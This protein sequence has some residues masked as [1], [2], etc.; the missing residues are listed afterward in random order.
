MGEG[1]V[2]IRDVSGEKVGKSRGGENGWVKKSNCIR[3]K[4]EGE[5][6]G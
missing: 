6:M 5:E 2:E 1:K 3:H 4:E